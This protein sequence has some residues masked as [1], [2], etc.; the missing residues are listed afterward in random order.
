MKEKDTYRV[1]ERFFSREIVA[2]VTDKLLVTDA[3]EYDLERGYAF[4]IAA[5]HNGNQWSSLQAITADEAER[6]GVAL[7]A[8]AARERS[9]Y[10]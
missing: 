7:I 2:V 3:N 4:Q 6:L 5:T 8:A 9:H 1:G 10:A